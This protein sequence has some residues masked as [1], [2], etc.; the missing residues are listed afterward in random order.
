MRTWIS[1]MNSV[2]VLF[3]YRAYDVKR[4]SNHSAPYETI[5]APNNPILRP[6][7][8]AVLA[9]P[10]YST[11]VRTNPGTLAYECPGFDSLLHDG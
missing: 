9:A 4:I 8:P 3:R 11:F 5:V 7:E 2:H 1:Y 6:N 10:F